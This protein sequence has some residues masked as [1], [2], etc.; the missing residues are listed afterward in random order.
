MGMKEQTTQEEAAARGMMEAEYDQLAELVTALQA[1]PGDDRAFEKFYE[2][3]YPRILYTSRSLV[4]SEQS[5]LDVAQEVYLAFYKNLAN[6]RQPRAIVS[7]LH[8]TATGKAKDMRERASAQNETLLQSEE[9]EYVFTNTEEHRADFVPHEQLDARATREIISEMLTELPAEQSQILVYR[10][11]EGL[12]LAEIA[13]IMDCTVSTVKSRLKYG[14]AKI[15]EQVTAMEKKGIKLYS[16]SIPML[17]A[18]LRWLMAERGALAAEQAAGL[19]AQVESTVGLT[20]SAAA[21]AATKGSAVGTKVVAGVAA[22]AVIAGGVVGVS[23]LK[24]RVQVNP[25]ATQAVTLSAEEQALQDDYN[26]NTAYLKVISDLQE[27]F[28][29]RTQ[30]S[31]NAYSGLL[32][33][34]LV[35]FD[36][37]GTDELLCVCTDDILYTSGGQMP[38]VNADC[39]YMVYRWNGTQAEQLTDSEISGGYILEGTNDADW[40]FSDFYL[41]QD[42]T[43]SKIYLCTDSFIPPSG[44][45]DEKEWQESFTKNTVQDGKWMKTWS[46]AL[47]KDL[48]NGSYLSAWIYPDKRT[49]IETSCGSVEQE[50]TNTRRNSTYYRITDLNDPSSPGE[51]IQSLPGYPQTP[52]GGYAPPE[53]LNILIQAMQQQAEQDKQ[54]LGSAFQEFTADTS[55]SLERLAGKVEHKQREAVQQNSLS[56]MSVNN[57]VMID[58][59]TVAQ[60]VAADQSRRDRWN[61]VCD[62]MLDCIRLAM[63]QNEYQKIAQGQQNWETEV[64]QADSTP[65]YESNSVNDYKAANWSEQTKMY[66]EHAEYLN[67]YYQVAIGSIGG[68]EEHWASENSA[69]VDPADYIGHWTVDQYA[70]K[71]NTSVDIYLEESN[72][73]LV[74]S[75]DQWLVQWTTAYDIPLTLNDNK[76]RAIGTYTDSQGNFGAIQ[77]DFENGELYATTTQSGNFG[78]TMYQDRCT[79]DS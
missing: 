13:E 44:A 60:L 8:R 34:K 76:T 7:W 53:D 2:L 70:D 26:R 57:T 61:A 58:S 68:L 50:Y 72:G 27:E 4:N 48:G 14:K 16:T 69:A 23:K 74:V 55:A 5:A 40:R 18:C 56:Q 43:D 21:G 49:Q 52:A 62:A 11:V 67:V 71:S 73:Q 77:L 63:P 47:N 30:I 17:L 9:Q 15:E 19:L 78:F 29:V 33:A 25:P 20:A 64:A 24:A 37:D 46:A 32:M 6:I 12:P 10:F 1:N 59:Q 41:Y 51:P 28:G 36:A 39:W 3:T 54:Q 75:V 66:E 31:D 79:R 45:P 38:G 42:Q 35:D 65:W 22:A